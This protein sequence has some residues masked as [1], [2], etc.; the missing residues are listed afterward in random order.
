[1]VSIPS[2]KKKMIVMVYVSVLS[3]FNCLSVF[4]Q[5]FL[6]WEAKQSP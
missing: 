3:V 4:A 2:L 6:F 5:E 1:M